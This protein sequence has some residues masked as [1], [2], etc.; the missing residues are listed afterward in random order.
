MGMGQAAGAAAAM[1]VKTGIN[2]DELNFQDIQKNLGE[3]GCITNEK[4][5]EK[6]RRKK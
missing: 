1:S 3:A 2:P 4:Q 5:I 6:V